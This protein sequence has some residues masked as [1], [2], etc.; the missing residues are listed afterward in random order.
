MRWPLPKG[1]SA[2]IARTPVNQRLRNVLAFQRTWGGCI[3]IVLRVR[4]DRRAAIHRPSEAVQ[5]TPEQRGRAI[6][7][8]LAWPGDHGIAGLQ[9]AGFFQWHQQHAAVAKADYLRTH[10]SRGRTES[11]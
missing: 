4:L 6:D 10:P 3:K 1:S 7:A 2:S 9:P 11:R 5:H 8:R